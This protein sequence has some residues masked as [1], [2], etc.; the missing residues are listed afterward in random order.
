VAVGIAGIETA[1]PDGI[2]FALLV[3]TPARRLSWPRVRVTRPR[4]SWQGR[5]LSNASE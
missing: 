2:T 3:A 4:E 1:R 5:V